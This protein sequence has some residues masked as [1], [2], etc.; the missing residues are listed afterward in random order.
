MIQFIL[1]LLGLAFSNNN[2]NTTTSDNNPNP[3]TMQSG[4]P[5]SGIDPG[6]GG[7]TGGDTIQV[8][9]KK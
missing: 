3:V 1:M 6:E 4:I 2:A 8:P 9:P 5:G 7:D